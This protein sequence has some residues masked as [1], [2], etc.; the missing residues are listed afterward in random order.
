MKYIIKLIAL[1]LALIVSFSAGAADSGEDPMVNQRLFELL[2]K[3]ESATAETDPSPQA[4][5]A[6]SGTFKFIITVSNISNI[7][8][9]MACNGQVSHSGGFFYSET[10]NGRIVWSGNTGTCTIYMRYFWKAAD[11][12]QKVNLFV[13]IRPF[14][15]C[16][17]FTPCIERPISRNS[18]HQLASIP[19]P[20]NGDLTII[21]DLFRL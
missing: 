2:K 8:E 14:Y 4:A 5:V 13:S 16:T 3:F 6:A 17:A 7:T 21:T 1:N 9:P 20:A 18:S 10:A 12:L 11:T 19:L 15:P